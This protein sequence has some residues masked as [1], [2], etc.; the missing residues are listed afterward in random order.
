MATLELV[1]AHYDEDLQWLRRVPDAFRITVYSKA[2]AE[3]IPPK[4]IALPNVGEEAHTYFHHMAERYDDLADVTVFAQGKPFDHVPDF[5]RTLKQLA[6]ARLHVKTFQW[7]GFII[8]QDDAKGSRLFEKWHPGRTLPCRE[9]W[10]T[11]W[12]EKPPGA[13]TFYPGAH[14]IVSEA[15]LRHRPRDF[16]EKARTLCAEIRYA[17]HCFERCWDRVFDVDGIPDAFKNAEYPVYLRPVKR[18]GIT[19]D[20]VP[21]GY[22]PWKKHAGE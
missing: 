10:Q 12:A 15:A 2:E 11:L 5:H 14:F 1:V 8:D 3:Q 13:L 4:A 21:E 20:D 16:Y 6:A 17:S 19:W 22:R 18:M 9:V 7:L